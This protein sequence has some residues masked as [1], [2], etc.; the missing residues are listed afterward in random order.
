MSDALVH[1]ASIDLLA[2]ATNVD[3]NPF[4]KSS[5]LSLSGG[6]AL[7]PSN[8]P[9]GTVP[10]GG[11]I[12]EGGSIT[13]YT[14]EEGDS[15]SEI[16]EEYGVSV[17]TILW[18]NDISNA[19]SVRPG[20]ELIILP[21]SG[22]RHSVGRGDTLGSLASEYGA[23]ADDIASFNGLDEDATLVSGSDI[24][25][26]GGEFK[27]APKEKEATKKAVVAATKSV[28]KTGGSIAD[29]STATGGDAGSGFFSNPV[30]G[31]LVTQGV[32]GYNGVDLGAPSGTSVYAAA[33]GTVSVSKIG[34]YNGG[35]G[36]YVVIDHGGGVQTLYSH[37]DSDLVS[38]GE[39]VGKG[40][41]I[42]T[43]GITGAATGYH[44]HFEVRGAKNPYARCAEMTKCS[45]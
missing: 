15:L 6:S 13:T 17:S 3:P 7:M 45:P 9:L 12:S 26:P 11:A 37:L 44:L 34:G 5:R 35:Y 27:A 24:I 18:A 42:G 14:V 2:A 4:K 20:D 41:S 22:I 21:V 25:I 29:V 28:V 36:N 32:H 40:Q 10:E 8:G 31:A 30:R 43:V 23:N 19:N 1:D 16:A 39:K 33:G 38:V